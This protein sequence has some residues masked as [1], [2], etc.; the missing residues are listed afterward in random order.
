VNEYAR[1][2]VSG[3]FIP[4]RGNDIDT[5][6]IIPARY[7]K[8]VT[9]AGLGEHVFEDDR[10]QT[11]HHPFDD[12]RFRGASILVVGLNF[13]CGSSREHAPQALMR[14]GVKAVVGGS[15]A[16][17]FFGN[18]TTLGVPCV[19]AEMTDVEWLWAEVERNPGL[20]GV[21]DLEARLLRLG[22]RTIPVRIPEGARAQLVAGTWDATGV[23]LDAGEAIERT[24]RGLPYVT[25]F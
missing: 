24:A 11:R 10:A 4:L 8:S 21:V 5:D 14:W 2:Q 19:T 6:R 7:L 20:E 9:F 25:G 16:E 23:L 15:F 3:R 1:R 12:A 13:G 18:A 22:E 17:I